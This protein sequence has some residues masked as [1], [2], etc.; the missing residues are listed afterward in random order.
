MTLEWLS[1]GSKPSWFAL[2]CPLKNRQSF[3]T[4]RPDLSL[5]W[6]SL[7]N[8]DSLP[9]C[10]THGHFIPRIDLVPWRGMKMLL[11][12]YL[13][14]NYQNLMRKTFKKTLPR[15][16]PFAERKLSRE[17][18]THF[19]FD[20]VQAWQSSRSFVASVHVQWVQ[21]HGQSHWLR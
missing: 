13:L 18:K 10:L 7:K 9:D 5:L 21:A 2:S 14:Y 20:K 17:K 15:K 12:I 4:F 6:V 16:V 3:Q 8:G 19:P 11:S 1:S